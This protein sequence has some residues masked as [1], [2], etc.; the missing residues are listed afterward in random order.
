M[1]LWDFIVTQLKTN[2]FASAAILAMPAALITY[3]IR[4]IPLRIWLWIKRRSTLTVRFNSDQLIFTEA[5]EYITNTIISDRFSRNYVFSST[6]KVTILPGGRRRTE[7]ASRNIEIGYG[8]H[9]GFYKRRL[10]IIYRRQDTANQSEKFKEYCTCNFI[11]NS[12]ALIA[13]FKDEMDAFVEAKQVDEPGVRVRA[14]VPQDK[15]GN[16]ILLPLRSIDTIFLPNNLGQELVDFVRDFESKREFNL[17][18]GLPNHTGILLPGPPGT[19]KSSLIHAIASETGRRIFYLTLNKVNEL[20]SLLSGVIDWST[21]FLVIEDI[22]AS[23]VPLKRD[24]DED[25]EQKRVTANGITL[26]ALLNSIDGLLT[27]DG[28]IIIA[29]T[30]HLEKLDP[31]LRRPGRFD[32]IVEVTFGGKPEFEGMA[33]LFDVDPSTYSLPYFY[34]ISGSTTRKLL[35]AGG[36]TAVEAHQRELHQQ[37]Q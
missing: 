34:P 30:N 37:Q 27:P 32:K 7:L 23:G 13:D 1:S 9:I 18:K 25:A 20:S 11:T 12:K 2:Q 24:E 4:Q 17:A 5:M 33:K 3:T 16:S 26:S 22:D 21:A 35:L 10:V 6:E 29:T 15:W 28:L 19:G 8:I 14:N 31:A 36:V